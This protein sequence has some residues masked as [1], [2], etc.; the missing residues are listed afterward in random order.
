MIVLYTGIKYETILFFVWLNL[1]FNI[2][3]LESLF[4]KPRLSNP[5]IKQSKYKNIFFPTKNKSVF[6]IIGYKIK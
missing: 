4:P 3:N 1:Y 2:T 6:K 5:E